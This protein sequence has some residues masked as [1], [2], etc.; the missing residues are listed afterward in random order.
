M[1][2]ENKFNIAGLGEL[3]WDLFPGNK[4]PGGAPANVAYHASQWG[5]NGIVLS[6]V[7]Y[8][9]QG[10]ELISYLK[11]KNLVVDYIQRDGIHPTGSVNVEFD[12]EEPVYTIIEGVAW[13]HLAFTEE[14]NEV[15][16]SLDAI[17]FGTLAQR[18][19]KSRGTIYKLLDSLPKQTLKVLDVNLREPFYNRQIL[20]ESIKR[21]D[22][23]KVNN[24]EF[25]LL[26]EL[27]N[28]S[29]LTDWFFTEMNIEIICLTKGS[30][31]S[32]LITPDHHIQ[33]EPA[34]VDTSTGDAVGVGDAFTASLMCNVLCQETLQKTLEKANAYAG[35][36]VTKKGGMPELPPNFTSQLT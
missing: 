2:S 8:D 16:K 11:N 26:E 20:L 23:I 15:A 30:E 13:D 7:G 33:V 5:A 17:C 31:G 36:I 28:P 18:S 14:W 9:E 34:S 21:C 10:S 25:Q 1:G 3:L 22:I 24:H 29:D 6:R 35:S 19:E 32:E 27:F 4:R 12:E